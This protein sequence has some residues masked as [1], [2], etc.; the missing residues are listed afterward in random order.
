MTESPDPKN[1]IVEA[2]DASFQSEAVE[3]SR[4]VLVVVDFWAAWCQPCRMLGPILEQLARE[5]DGKFVLV[6]V[7]TEKAPGIAGGF[8]VQSIPA[9]YAMRDGQLLDYFVGLLPEGQIRG[10]IDRLLPTPAEQLVAESRQLES[11]DDSAAEAKL[12]EAIELDPNLAAASIALAE[13]LLRQGR[14]DDSRAVI[15]TL[16][17]RGFLEPEAEKVK[18]ELHMA[19]QADKTVDLEA[20]RKR[21]ADEPQ[22]LQARLE[23]AEGLAAAKDYEPALQTALA[24]VETHN[25]EFVDPARGLMIDVFRLLDDSGPLVTEYRRRLSTALY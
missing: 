3:R 7:D 10:W 16:E 21:V 18:A 13:L 19:E 11:T 22:N 2:D 5:Y 20:L 15:E 23:L 14:T 8:G 9:V 24:I 25:K 4:D 6:K 12:R 1:W 17:Q